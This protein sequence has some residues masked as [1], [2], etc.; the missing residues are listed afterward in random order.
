MKSRAL[1]AL[2][3]LALLTTGCSMNNNN[4]WQTVVCSV[5]TV[6]GGAPVVSA[7]LNNGGTVTPDDDFVPLDMIKVMFAARPYSSASTIT[8]A[9]AYSSFIITG[10]SATWTPG[11][12]APAELT[13]YNVDH[14]SLSARVPVNN[15]LEVQFMLCPQEIK[16]EAWYPVAGSATIF[17]AD[18]ELT[19][20]GHVEGS[21]HEVAIPS[22]TTVTFLGAIT[23]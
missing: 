9:G 17:T 21:E 19:F 12:N 6:N 14:A 16:Q 22:G 20:Y 7:A 15:E 11:P 3:A 18:L 10:Y 23:N 2:L 8:S 1:L 5:K 13:T 4:E